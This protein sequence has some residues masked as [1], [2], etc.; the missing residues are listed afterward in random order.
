MSFAE[1]RELVIRVFAATM[2]REKCELIELRGQRKRNK[3][4][5]GSR[6]FRRTVLKF[7]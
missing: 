4:A 5:A 7:V 6:Q 3:D 2:C 1:R